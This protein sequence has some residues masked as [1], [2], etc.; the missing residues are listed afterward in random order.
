MAYAATALSKFL[1]FES[2]S[3]AAKVSLLPNAANVVSGC[4]SRSDD[5]HADY[6]RDDADRGVD[7][8]AHRRLRER[9]SV[10][11]RKE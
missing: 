1:T 10:P 11:E 7:V 6:L 5:D 9:E 4:T 3:W 2:K 8:D